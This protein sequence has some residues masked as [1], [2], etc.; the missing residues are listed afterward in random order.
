MG[1]VS[2]YETSISTRLH[3]ATSQKIGFYNSNDDLWKNSNDHY[4]TMT[5]GSVLPT[6]TVYTD[7]NNT[8]QPE[9]PIVSCCMSTQYV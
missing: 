9:Q 1:V 3:S 4:M 6:R 7:I 5:V 2:S 8:Y